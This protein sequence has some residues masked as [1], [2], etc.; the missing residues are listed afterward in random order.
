LRKDSVI[1]KKSIANLIHESLWDYNH[2]SG[3]SNEAFLN[4]VQMLIQ[5]D[6]S[7][8]NIIGQDGY[9]LLH[10]AV[11]CKNINLVRYL[12]Q[13]GAELNMLT[14]SILDE[15]PNLR[16]P[17]MTAIDIALSSSSRETTAIV[18]LLAQSSATIPH[19]LS[20]LLSEDE[21][22][23]GYWA[24]SPAN[25][26]AQ[27]REEL[28]CLAANKSGLSES[29][30]TEILQLMKQHTHF[31]TWGLDHHE[32]TFLHLAFYANHARIIQEWLA[33]PQWNDLSKI[34]NKNNLSLFDIIAS[35]GFVEHYERLKHL[36]TSQSDWAR[37]LRLSI[38]NGHEGFV[39]R[40]LAEGVSPDAVYNGDSALMTAASKG[41]A[42]LLTLLLT[43]GANPAFKTEE[44]EPA[45]SLWS[46]SFDTNPVAQFRRELRSLAANKSD[47]S[48]SRK[49]ELLQLIKQHTHFLTWGLN[50][51]E[52]TF[53]H[54]AFNANHARLIQ[55]LVDL[56][57]W[58]D[59][60]KTVNKGNCSLFDVIA[61]NGFEE[62]YERLKHLLTSQS[63]WTYALC[64]SVENGHEGFV[65]RLLADGDSDY[66][67]DDSATAEEAWL[68]LYP[69]KKNPFNLYSRTKHLEQKQA[70]LIEIIQAQL[71]NQHFIWTNNFKKANELLFDLQQKIHLATFISTDN[72]DKTADDALSEIITNWEFDHFKSDLFDQHSPIGRTVKTITRL[73][74]SKLTPSQPM[75]LNMPE[76]ETG[77]TL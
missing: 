76:S 56:P 37:A 22:R 54:L 26:V 60:S 41:H 62:H 70:Q 69:L 38:A 42:P 8:I 39:R 7:L 16:Y 52:S 51:N 73:L 46:K 24:I 68:K 34:V 27:F 57:Q 59:L 5:H 4:K 17:S 36:P 61:S 32:S 29:R 1:T 21:I 35:N 3:M 30:K 53:L 48:E 11:M 47:L 31:L 43:F 13:E 25:P 75:P 6:P 49:T 40:L 19:T 2:M 20:A 28:Y 58:N 72:P 66:S 63:D 50:H 45:E 55:E 71:P 9:T 23:T 44:S 74:H 12:I 15:H 33:L 67:I 14:P 18:V 77:Y 64:L 10:I 65:R